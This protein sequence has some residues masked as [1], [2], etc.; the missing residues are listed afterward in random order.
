MVFGARVC[1]SVSRACKSRFS[2]GEFRQTRDKDRSFNRFT[3]HFRVP[4]SCSVRIG[5]LGFSIL[6]TKGITITIDSRFLRSFEAVYFQIFLPRSRFVLKEKESFDFFF[7]SCFKYSSFDL[8]I[9][10]VLFVMSNK[11]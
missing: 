5:N 8:R 4:I 1:K 7:E 6:S 10:G 9:D 11:V 3:N 2:I